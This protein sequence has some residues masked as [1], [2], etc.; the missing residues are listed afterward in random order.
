VT[1]IASNVLVTSL[2]IFVLR[3]RSKVPSILKRP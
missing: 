1:T 3:A 2:S